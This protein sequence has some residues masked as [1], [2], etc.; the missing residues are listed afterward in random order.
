MTIQKL[1]GKLAEVIREE[2]ALVMK[3]REVQRERDGLIQAIR[4]APVEVAYE[5]TGEQTLVRP[6]MDD[7]AYSET[8]KLT[9]SGNST[10]E[11]GMSAIVP[12]PGAGL[13]GFEKDRRCREHRRHAHTAD[14]KVHV[15][16]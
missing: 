6:Y 7:A 12:C 5:N 8:M 11:V 4:E 13:T 2:H 14:G 10:I 16:S 3:L 1:G 9:V 15:L